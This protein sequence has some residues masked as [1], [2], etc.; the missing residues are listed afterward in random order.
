MFTDIFQEEPTPWEGQLLSSS[1]LLIVN[2]MFVEQRQ[3]RRS[4]LSLEVQKMAEGKTLTHFQVSIHNNH[5]TN[6][7]HDHDNDF[8]YWQWP[9]W[10][11]LWLLHSSSH[12][13]G[14]T[15]RQR[16]RALRIGKSTCL[17]KIEIR[18]YL[19]G[20][21]GAYTSGSG[22]VSHFWLRASEPFYARPKPPKL[23]RARPI[24]GSIDIRT[25][26]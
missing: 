16:W 7:H 8:L 17:Q 5:D 21:L 18:I 15:R 11:K 20:Q 3:R 24:I 10:G 22:W 6:H 14:R 25:F 23:S 4:T 26:F 9:C 2:E 1:V 13:V 19:K 12:Q